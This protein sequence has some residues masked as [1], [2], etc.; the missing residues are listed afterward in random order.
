MTGSEKGL[1]VGA[2]RPDLSWQSLVLHFH[3]LSLLFKSLLKNK[4]SSGRSHI[5]PYSFMLVGEGQ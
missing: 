5:K 3:L 1:K 2:G 4:L